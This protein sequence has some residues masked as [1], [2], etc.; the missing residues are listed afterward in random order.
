VTL[1]FSA[2]QALHGLLTSPT[3]SGKCSAAQA[4]QQ[5]KIVDRVAGRESHLLPRFCP[6]RTGFNGFG[7]T[8]ES[9]ESIGQTRKSRYELTQPDIFARLTPNVE[10]FTN[11]ITWS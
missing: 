4:S 1:I 11:E 2:T 5:I 10:F 3:H 7:L 6:H 8:N 9:F